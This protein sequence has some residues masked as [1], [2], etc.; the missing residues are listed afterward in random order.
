M[1]KIIRPWF[2]IHFVIFIGFLSAQTPEF[3]LKQADGYY[4]NKQFNKANEIFRQISGSQKQDADF[5]LKRAV[6]EFETNHLD[7]AKSLANRLVDIGHN[8]PD[9]TY[10]LRGKIEMA[11][12]N[13]SRAALRFKEGLATLPPGNK[14]RNLMI[15]DI[16]RCGEGDYWVQ[17]ADQVLLESAGNE[18]NTIWDETKPI[19]SIHVDSKFYFN[20]NREYPGSIGNSNP[21]YEL[22]Y[23][24]YSTSLYNGEWSEITALNAGLSSKA[25]DILVDFSED[26]QIVYFKTG[27]KMDSLIFKADTFSQEIIKKNRTGLIDIPYFNPEDEVYY[28]SDSFVLFSSIRPGGLGGYDIYFTRLTDHKWI[29]PQNLGKEINSRFDEISPYMAFDGRTLVFSS[30]STKSIGGYDLFVSTFDDNTLKWSTPTNLGIPLNSSADEKNF[31]L[32]K[33]K[34]SAVFASDR[35]TGTGG[36]DI[37]FAYFKNAWV[38]QS[39]RSR[40]VL[41]ADVESKQVNQDPL[42][43]TA[44]STSEKIRINDF[45]IYYESEEQIE[46]PAIS[47]TLIAV[48]TVFT[49][50]PNLI[51]TIEVF[52]ENGGLNKLDDHLHSIIFAEKIKQFFIDQGNKASRIIVKGYG[53][54]FPVAL[55]LVN[56]E[57]NHAGQALNKRVEFTFFDPNPLA[58]ERIDQMRSS[59]KVSEIMASNKY[60]DFRDKEKSL[61]YK[62]LLLSGAN[63]SSLDP[64]IAFDFSDLFIEKNNLNGRFELLTKGYPTYALAKAVRKEL[65]AR[66]FE[67]AG[68]I[69]YYSNERIQPAYLSK[70]AE[71][72]PDLVNYIY[73]SE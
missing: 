40:P 23:D 1:I 2:V 54:S 38:P 4:T 36:F 70:W 37:Y 33:N 42:T 67:D 51:L 50:N 18:V 24:M 63:L 17:Q 3:L 7:S 47:K 41:F 27:E 58:N 69:A 14:L 13:F 49:K 62:V 12:N 71:K 66:G 60:Q 15:D 19:Y 61:N 44:S 46:L 34:L 45:K 59:P 31:R 73:R 64:N 32:N 26:G 56:G 55:E 68:I 57:I 65:V 16:K 10:Y 43:K 21:E 28:F 39:E 25:H 11:K 53:S 52:K 6:C 29:E 5:L 22:P 20:S 30:N 9:L 35:K 48:N 8:V 72:N